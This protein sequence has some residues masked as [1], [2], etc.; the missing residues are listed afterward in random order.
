MFQGPRGHC[1]LPVLSS[2]QVGGR[3][4]A[5][6]KVGTVVLRP[7]CRE[8]PSLPSP[9]NSGAVAHEQ[10]HSRPH[11][12]VAQLGLKQEGPGTGKVCPQHSPS[13]ELP[14]GW[15]VAL[16]SFYTMLLTT[17]AT[18]SALLSPSCAF[19]RPVTCRPKSLMLILAIHRPFPLCAGE[20]ALMLSCHVASR[21]AI[22]S[23]ALGQAGPGLELWEESSRATAGVRD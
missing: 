17:S 2:T 11:I 1:F 22:A 14:Q 9:S 6:T 3:E 19:S 5:V 7:S 16:C 10:G 13:Q 21:P 15:D 23:S 12:S 20:E 8:L 4:G 18:G